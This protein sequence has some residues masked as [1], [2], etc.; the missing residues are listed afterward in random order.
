MCYQ[1]AAS[2]HEINRHTMKEA[3]TTIKREFTSCESI[4]SFQTLM[5]DPLCSLGAAF[6]DEC[7]RCSL[8]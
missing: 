2:R 1:L 7:G 3:L 6:L 4:P 8:F 5:S